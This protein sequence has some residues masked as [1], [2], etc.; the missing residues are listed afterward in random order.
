MT[1]ALWCVF[2]AALLPFPFTLAAKWSRRF[3]NA[4]PRS[5]L[6]QNEGWR[7]RANWAQ[8]NSFEAF[9]A[10]AAAVIIAHI[11]KGPSAY[12]DNL[13]LAFI[14]LRIA[15]GLLYI[16]DKATARS[17]AWTAAIGCTI[18]IFIHAA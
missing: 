5:S 9:P 17:L 18:A 15:F 14:A 11:V 12:V 1:V 3:D 2:V 7:Q 6:E 13:A 4:R 8:L 10:F 16:A